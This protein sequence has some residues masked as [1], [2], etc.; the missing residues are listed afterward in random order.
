MAQHDVAGSRSVS[1][2]AMARFVRQALDL[3]GKRRSL[4][5]S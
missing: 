3:P 4:I 2:V 5:F 1:R